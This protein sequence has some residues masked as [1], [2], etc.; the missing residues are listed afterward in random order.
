MKIYYCRFGNR[1]TLR[2]PF[3]SFDSHIIDISLLVLLYYYP[4]VC[5]H[6]D[7]SP[8]LWTQMFYCT[9]TEGVCLKPYT[10]QKEN[11]HCLT[12]SK[13]WSLDL[14]AGLVT[15]KLPRSTSCTWLSPCAAANPMRPVAENKLFSRQ[16][17]LIPAVSHHY[18]CDEEHNSR[19]RGE[20]PTALRIH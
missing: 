10:E 9:D 2:F 20:T 15:S 5:W 16:V 13:L 3:I 14:S 6:R 17:W 12:C 19:C 1:P 11:S 8:P 4:I 18:G 7:N